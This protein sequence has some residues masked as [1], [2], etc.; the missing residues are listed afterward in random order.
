MNNEIVGTWKLLS[1]HNSLNDGSKIY[2]FGPDATGYISYS[3]DGHVFVHIMA[4]NR[5]LYEGT[6]PFNGTSDEDAAAIKS[7]I[8]YAGKYEFIDD[9]L[10]H[11]TKISSFPNWVGTDQ[12]R[13]YEID[14][15]KLTLSASGARFKGHE[16]TA[17]LVWQR[18]GS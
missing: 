12:V 17:T 7:H 14:G 9:K 4:A 5:A 8:S 3:S 16:V 13:D 2:N 10:V 15:D 1:W 11:H 6:D 18:A